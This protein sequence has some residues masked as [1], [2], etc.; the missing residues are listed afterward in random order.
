ML[1]YKVV[2]NWSNSRWDMSNR[3]SS[4]EEYL[5]VAQITCDHLRPRVLMTSWVG[6][7]MRRDEAGAQTCMLPGDV[8]C[9][10]SLFSLS[11]LW[12]LWGSGDVMGAWWW[13]W[14]WW[15]LAGE[16]NI[17]RGQGTDG[18][19]LPLHRLLPRKLSACSRDR[20][21]I[22]SNVYSYN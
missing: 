3:L 12:V 20:F 6:G 4:F 5:L 13:W 16:P 8:Q 2:N 10:L 7:G 21:K 17:P 19:W 22:T 1:Q 15:R 18:T 11:S 14:W 9:T